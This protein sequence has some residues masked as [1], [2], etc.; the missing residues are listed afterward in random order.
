M[1]RLELLR[2]RGFRDEKH[3]KEFLD[4]CADESWK[5]ELVEYFG[6]EEKTSKAKGKKSEE[7]V[8]DADVSTNSDDKNTEEENSDNTT[9]ETNVDGDITLDTNED[10]DDIKEG[11]EDNNEEEK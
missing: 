8:E 9:D 4:N 2:G 7:K 10:S 11:S 3:L 5:A 1:S 6:L